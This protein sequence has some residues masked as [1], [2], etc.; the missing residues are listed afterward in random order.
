MSDPTNDVSSGPDLFG[1]LAYEFADRLRRGERP[2]PT[3]YAERHPELAEQIHELFPALAE[4]EQLGSGMG[5]VTGPYAVGVD[6]D[7]TVPRVLGEYRV[8]REI[9]RGGMGV[10]YEAVQESLGRHVALKVMPDRRRLAPN[11]LERFIREAKAAA[12]LAPHQHRPGFWR[13]RP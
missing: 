10:V 7:A 9:G 12:L 4:M 8:V 2:T 6:R 3:E 11:Q 1:Q 13:R 5:P